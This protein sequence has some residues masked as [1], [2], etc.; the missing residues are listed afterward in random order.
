MGQSMEEADTRNE[1]L[2]PLQL[3]RR[4]TLQ[5]RNSSLRGDGD[6]VEGPECVSREDRWGEAGWRV[7]AYSRRMSTH[8]SCQEMGASDWRGKEA[9]NAGI[10]EAEASA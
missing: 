4:R 9:H 1:P 10:K 6:T 5:V 3:A 2:E 8:E 7:M